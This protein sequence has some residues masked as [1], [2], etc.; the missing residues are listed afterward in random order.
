MIQYS[1][2]KAVNEGF[3][4]GMRAHE[5][6]KFF[7][8]FVSSGIEKGH[9][10]LSSSSTPPRT[11]FSCSHLSRDG[12]MDAGWMMDDVK[13]LAQSDSYLQD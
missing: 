10:R 8:F 4:K 6:S 9:L 3:W 1:R 7:L 2:E 12:W 5:T 13:H 11:I